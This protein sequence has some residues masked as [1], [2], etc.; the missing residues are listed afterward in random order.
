ME[1]VAWEKE[2][3]AYDF[4]IVRIDGV[5][6]EDLWPYVERA[7]AKAF[8]GAQFVGGY[9]LSRV[10]AGARSSVDNPDI[11]YLLALG[12]NADGESAILGGILGL[13]MFRP[14]N[15]LRSTD[16][17][18]IFAD[19]DLP[20]DVKR[21][22]VEGL[23]DEAYTVM[24]EYDYKW[25]AATV[26]TEAGKRAMARVFGARHSPLSNR[27]VR[28]VPGYETRPPLEAAEAFLDTEEALKV[29]LAEKSARMARNVARFS[30]NGEKVVDSYPLADDDFKRLYDET[31]PTLMIDARCSFR[32]S[33]LTA[34]AAQILRDAHDESAKLN[35]VF[36]LPDTK[37]TTLV[38]TAR[39]GETKGAMCAT[40]GIL[41]DANGNTYAGKFPH[42]L[43]SSV[44][45]TSSVPLLEQCE[46]LN[47]PTL[48]GS[49][50]FKEHEHKENV[51]QVAAAAGIK[52]PRRLR[53]V[54]HLTDDDYPADGFVIKPS[55]ESGGGKGVQVYIHKLIPG[56][57]N[58]IFQA[59]SAGGKGAD[60]HASQSVGIN[61]KLLLADPWTYST[62]LETRGYHPYYEEYIENFPIYDKTTGKTVTWSVRHN[63][64]AG[65]LLGSFIRVN[66]LQD[67]I[68]YMQG[69]YGAALDELYDMIPDKATARSLIEQIQ[70]DGERLARTI[71][72]GV[73]GVDVI[74]SK[75]RESYLIEVNFG[76]VGGIGRQTVLAPPDDKLEPHAKL[77]AGVLEKIG[78][79]LYGITPSDVFY[80]IPSKRNMVTL[81]KGLYDTGSLAAFAALK[82]EE[83][84]KYPVGRHFS[85]WLWIKARLLVH[86]E[87]RGSREEAEAIIDDALETT[88]LS[89]LENLD[90]IV[91]QQRRP[92]YFYKIVSD[93]AGQWP[94]FNGI[95]NYI[96][97]RMAYMENPPY[98]EPIPK[99]TAYESPRHSAK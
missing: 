17:G 13:P 6:L 58:F 10:L 27:W 12:E 93:L 65:K 55:A 46:D 1:R 45:E 50:E 56:G 67:S 85:Y 4:N 19:P 34:Q 98:A 95:H 25:M 75:E 40:H 82:K 36:V 72:A 64:A 47:V 31:L 11:A 8:E 92:E 22:L 57:M 78:P 7:V 54:P 9:D 66:T 2:P 63:I 43:F 29:I 33:E 86:N 89:F 26:G 76:Q 79:A 28:E 44:V 20:P 59:P 49:A 90:A 30:L 35:I 97:E 14:P 77:I 84:A 96:K 37:S 51:A 61:G 38:T 87:T 83:I 70:A 42:P 88:P 48:T 21:E 60:M 18:W 99:A 3:P 73:A 53:K 68:N 74:I 81:F 91:R 15:K 71:D 94:E 5:D 16:I 52:S 80:E 39:D 23:K 41:V 32:D 69:T 62:L 24:Y